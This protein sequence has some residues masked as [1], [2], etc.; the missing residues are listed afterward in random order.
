V[1]ATSLAGAAGTL[2]AVRTVDPLPPAGGVVHVSGALGVALTK[3]TPG[4]SWSL[5]TKPVEVD[6][7]VANDQR[8]ATR[9]R[10]T[11]P[12]QETH[13]RDVTRSVGG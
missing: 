2:G 6:G 8:A 7:P 3:A 11:Y 4:G 5:S 9:H 13:P 10:D 12:S 1:S